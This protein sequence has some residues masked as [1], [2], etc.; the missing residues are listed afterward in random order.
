M[1][2]KT[3]IYGILYSE[4]YS[5]CLFLLVPV[6]LYLVDMLFALLIA[7]DR[8][9]SLVELWCLFGLL[10]DYMVFNDL[11]HR[12]KKGAM[13]VCGLLQSSYSGK[14]LLLKGILADAL[15]RFL[16]LVVLTVIALWLNRYT[17][18]YSGET[19]FTAKT[20]VILVL[21]VYLG[22]TLFLNVLRYIHTFGIYWIGAILCS[23][24]W[25]LLMAIVFAWLDI[26]PEYMAGTGVVLLVLGILATAISCWH[27]SRRYDAYFGKGEK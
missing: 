14:K 7:G 5:L 10:G 22:N 25:E 15:R 24:I 27:M 4:L 13:P 18:V 12:C 17:A 23:T 21:A 11:F 3:N 9:L 19:A 8:R 20:A 16:Q 26:Y 6:F 2:R 1:K